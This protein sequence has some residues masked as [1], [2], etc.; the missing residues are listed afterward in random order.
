MWSPIEALTY[1]A[2]SERFVEDLT[3]SRSLIRAPPDHLEDIKRN[4]IEAAA[5]AR[6]RVAYLSHSTIKKL[7]SEVY[8]SGQV[9]R[10][11][12]PKHSGMIYSATHF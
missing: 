4:P 3:R 8:S 6:I 12:H 10:L 11:V 7:H 5:G 9:R 2:R 1:V